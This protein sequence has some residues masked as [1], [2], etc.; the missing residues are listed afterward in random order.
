MFKGYLGL[1]CIKV[2]CTNNN[3]KRVQKK[4]GEI[5]NNDMAILNWFEV[6]KYKQVITRLVTW[7][8]QTS[9]IKH[10]RIKNE[11]AEHLCV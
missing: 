6:N 10:Q 11:K 8:D 5:M 2:L 3:I 9:N 7:Y 1:F 4:S